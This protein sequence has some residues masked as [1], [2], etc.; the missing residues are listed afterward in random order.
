MRPDTSQP[1]RMQSKPN[2]FVTRRI[3]DAGMT[4]LRQVCEVRVWE[5]IS[6][7]PPSVLRREVADS[8]GL[9]CLHS[10]KVDSA[11]MDAAT[12]LRVISTYAVGYDNID[13]KAATE[14]GIPIGFTPDVL[15][16]AVADFAFLLILAIGRRLV[17]G[18]DYVRQG[19]EI[20][21]PSMFL[22]QDVHGAT[23]GI[24]GLGR[25]GQAVARRAA[26]FDMRIL[27]FD[28][29]CPST[30]A[31]DVNA[32]LVPLR[33]LLSGSDF[34]TLHIPLNDETQHLIDA[35]ALALMKPTGYLINTSRGPL[36]D[37]GALFASLKRGQ[38]AGAALDVTDPEPIAPDD[39][40]LA[41]PNVVIAPHISSAS[42]T[43][44]ERMAVL[45]AENL[46]AGVRGER[47]PHCVNPEVYR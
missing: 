42:V 12:R 29:C 23:L 11:V 43:A 36:I 9:L 32:H 18:S 44:R 39:P 24:V 31:R 16:E 20:V 37:Q 27:A 46:L 7:P 26:G 15:T 41:L 5:E 47:L 17:E 30:V 40:L 4:K 21:G 38:I 28:P 3:P 19:W 14:R 35:Q 22:G 10:D 33:D 34:V 8:D 13:M 6:P 1:E 45:S 25:I 2:V